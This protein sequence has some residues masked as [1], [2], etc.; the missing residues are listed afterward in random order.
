[1][2]TLTHWTRAYQLGTGLQVSLG[3][4]T[5]KVT[6]TYTLDNGVVVQELNGLYRRYLSPAVNTFAA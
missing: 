3:P 4:G 1:M 2:C 5:Y 6:K